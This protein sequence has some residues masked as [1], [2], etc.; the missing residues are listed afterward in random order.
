M[1]YPA[2]GFDIKLTMVKFIAKFGPTTTD[3]HVVFTITTQTGG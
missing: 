3:L 2:V 1:E